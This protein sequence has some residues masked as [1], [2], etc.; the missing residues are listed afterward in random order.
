MCFKGLEPTQ[1]MIESRKQAIKQQKCIPILKPDDDNIELFR[2]ED[3]EQIGQ[4]L[5]HDC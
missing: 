3:C 1:F 4:Y 2:V 5:T